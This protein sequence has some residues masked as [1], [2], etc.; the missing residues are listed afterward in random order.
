MFALDASTSIGKANFE[1]VVTFVKSIIDGL[2][3]GTTDSSSPSRIGMLTFSDHV[4]IQFQLKEYKNKYD[5]LNA[6][7]PYY[8]MGRTQTAQALSTMRT[9]MFTEG[10]GDQPSARNIAIVITDGYSGSERDTWREARRLREAG[11]ELISV[12]IGNSIRLRELQAIASYPNT[13]GKN[14]LKVEDFNALDSIRN[15]I[16]KVVCGS[17]CHLQIPSNLERFF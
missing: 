17:E 9:R 12:G 8:S 5:I 2:R 11:V 14:V 6:F 15:T 4:D 7:P 13:P 10:S 3:I 1:K 16:T